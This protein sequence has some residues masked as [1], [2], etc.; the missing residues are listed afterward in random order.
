MQI[1]VKKKLRPLWE[2]IFL[3]FFS[4][5][6]NIIVVLVIN[7]FRFLNYWKKGK[8]HAPTL[9]DLRCGWNQ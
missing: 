9:M 3:N 4:Y 7:G 2:F 6:T 1:Q 8:S 5:F